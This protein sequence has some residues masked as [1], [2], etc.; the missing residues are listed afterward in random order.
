MNKIFTHIGKTGKVVGAILAFI[1]AVYTTWNIYKRCTTVDIVGEWYL[2]FKVEKSTYKAYIGD[3]H[4]QKIYFNQI[5]NKVTGKG[6]KWEYNG[7]LLEYTKHRKLEY[8][9]NIKGREFKANYVLHGR[10]R[11]TTG[12]VIAK[13]SSDGKIMTGTFSGTAANSSGVLRGEKQIPE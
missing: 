6:E 2:E 13:I 9:G 4:T 7:E 5:E 3:M 1:I 8:E 12:F 11:E 10:D